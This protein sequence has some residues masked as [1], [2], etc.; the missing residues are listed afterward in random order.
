M[1]GM[2]FGDG[3]PIPMLASK[4]GEWDR[5]LVPETRAQGLPHA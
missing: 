1:I 3:I 2:G 5:Y 4:T